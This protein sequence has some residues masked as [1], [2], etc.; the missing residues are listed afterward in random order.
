MPWAQIKCG[1]CPTVGITI[2]AMCPTQNGA[3][4]LAFCGTKC[5]VLAGWPW[6][7]SERDRGTAVITEQRSLFEAAP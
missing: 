2:M 7:K 5:A 6:L 4:E 3:H 1:S